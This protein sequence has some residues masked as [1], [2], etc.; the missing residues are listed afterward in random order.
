MK[1]V[2]LMLG[3]AAA[4][5]TSCSNEEVV[6]VADGAAIKFDAF[7]NNNTKAVTELTNVTNFYVFGKAGDADVFL[8]ERNDVTKYWEASK[9]YNFAAYANGEDGK[10]ADATYDLTSKTITIPNYTPNDAKDLIAAV[11]AEFTTG[12]D[13]TGQQP[14][15]LSF[16]HMLS[17]VKFTFTTPEAVDYTIAISNIKVN[18]VKTAKGAYSAAGAVWTEGSTGEYVFTDIADIAVEGGKA[19]CDS[20][21]VIPQAGTDA[22]NV[23]FTA[24]MSG[25]G[26]EAKTKEFTA[27]LAVAQNVAGTS[28]ENTWMP[29]YRYNYTA[30]I[31][32]EKINSDLKKIEFTPSVDG[33]KDATNTDTEAN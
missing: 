32:A 29:G 23:T 3:V 10:L 30:E 16:K 24:T 12:S 7:V 1:K 27:T 28:A 5:L 9:A 4:A 18:A 17:Q 25:A 33:W 21:L 19:S 14:V 8:N 13:L 6:N 26:L 31:T 15:S 22:L 20:K 11:A 2:F